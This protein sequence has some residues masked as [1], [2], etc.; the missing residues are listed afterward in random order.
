M[1]LIWGTRER[2]IHAAYQFYI[3]TAVGTMFMLISIV[4]IYIYYHSWDF[5]VVKLLCT[6][7]S[8]ESIFL[9]IGFLLGFF[10]K[11]PLFPFHLWLTEAHVEAPTAGSILLAGILL[12]LS[13]YG[14][15]KIIYNLFDL[16]NL[17]FQDFIIVLSLFSIVYTSIATFFQTDIKKI[18]A[19]SS[20]GHMS[21]INIGLFVDNYYGLIGGFYGMIAHS[22]V[23]PALFACVGIIYERFH[24]KTISYYYKLSLIMPIFILF[25]CIFMLA[26]VNFPGTIGFYGELLILY[27]L[28][29][30]NFFFALL[31]SSISFLSVAYMF[32]LF[33]RFLYENVFLKNYSIYFDFSDINLREF[34]YLS[35]LLF[36]IIYF[37]LSNNISFYLN[38]IYLNIFEI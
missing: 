9:W 21:F 2:R 23:S 6:F 14:I 35:I 3:Y 34:Y 13:G 1:I 16:I 37:G 28:I 4:Y 15:I 11:M 24:N 31:G 7:S 10:V 38:L 27:S 8:F 19:Y 18:I 32:F 5:Y 20:I 26:N 36:F 29:K 22:F 17:Y 12:K 30:Y 33:I 25:F